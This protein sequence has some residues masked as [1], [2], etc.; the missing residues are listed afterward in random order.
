L[1][2]KH[3][4]TRIIRVNVDNAPF[5]VTKLQVKMLPCV[6]SF[7]DGLGVDRIIGFEGLGRRGGDDFT[8]KHLEDRLL[9]SGVLVRSKMDKGSSHAVLMAGQ[10]KAEQTREDEDDDE[11]D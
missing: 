6:I 11:W 9:Q 1:A 2:P 10:K 8:T 3:F 5:L 7:I 4:D